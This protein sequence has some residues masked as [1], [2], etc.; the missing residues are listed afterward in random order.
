MHSVLWNV[1]QLHITRTKASSHEYIEIV[2][3]QL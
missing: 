3:Y 1:G 2:N